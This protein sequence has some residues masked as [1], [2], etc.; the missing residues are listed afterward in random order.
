VPVTCLRN[1]AGSAWPIS[2]PLLGQIAEVLV[3]EPL[4]KETGGGSVVCV[5]AWVHVCA[6]ITPRDPLL[7]VPSPAADELALFSGV[8]PLVV[9]VFALRE[10]GKKVGSGLVYLTAS[11]SF[12]PSPTEAK[13]W[14]LVEQLEPLTWKVGAGCSHLGFSGASVGEAASVF[15]PLQ[16]RAA[17]R[18]EKFRG[19]A[20]GRRKGP[21][22]V[23]LVLLGWAQC[24][25]HG[26]GGKFCCGWRLGRR[27]EKRLDRV[28][29]DCGA[30]V[31]DRTADGYVGRPP[32]AGSVCAGHVLYLALYGPQAPRFRSKCPF[33]PCSNNPKEARCLG[34]F[35]KGALS[36]HM[37]HQHGASNVALADLP[38]KRCPLRS[39]R[40]HYLARHEGWFLW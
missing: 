3:A 16:N 4:V 18:A 20:A 33:L 2:P 22:S 34:A 19:S 6:S 12:M 31:V 25:G 35:W 21:V 8:F 37:H 14:K 11:L 5:R 7:S 39:S 32:S 13:V 27:M 38:D 17:D 23:V 29:R 15:A 9:D 40:A 24:P 36:R 10:A 26:C 1:V 28:L 30:P